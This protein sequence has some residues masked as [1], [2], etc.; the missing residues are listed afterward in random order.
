MHE[1][2][3]P[4]LNYTLFSG[5]VLR[6]SD[7]QRTSQGRYVISFE[8]ENTV[9][10]LD[11][12]GRSYT[13]TSTIDVEAWGRLAEETSEMFRQHAPDG[14]APDRHVMVEGRLASIYYEDRAG[15]QRHRVLVRAAMVQSL[16]AGDSR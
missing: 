14:R 15:N 10:L 9:D 7:L 11:A 8:V 3:P 1:I 12:E 16:H 5:R 2:S 6:Y 4:R 13:A